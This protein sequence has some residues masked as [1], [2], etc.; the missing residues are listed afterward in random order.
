MSHSPN[1][2]LTL[3]EYDIRI[4]FTRAATNFTS[5]VKCDFAEEKKFSV[6]G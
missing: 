3:P 4:Y 5:T 2:R 1:A 6:G